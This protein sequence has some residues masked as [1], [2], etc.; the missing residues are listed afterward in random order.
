VDRT[1]VRAV[2]EWIRAQD[3]A[4]GGIQRAFTYKALNAVIQGSAADLMKKAMVNVWEAGICDILGSPLL[5]V[6]DEMDF[7]VPQTKEGLEAWAECVWL[8]ETALE[9]RVP[10][11]VDGELKPNWGQNYP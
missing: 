2:R 1:S 3:K 7:S 10:I 6:H 9:F 5:T 8:M 4:R 11:R